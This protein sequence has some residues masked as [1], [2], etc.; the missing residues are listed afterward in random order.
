M[1]SLLS[2]SLSSS[3]SIFSS[4]LHAVKGSVTAVGTTV[5]D[6]VF[7]HPLRT[8]YFYGPRLHG[9]GFWGGLSPEDSC[10]QLT[11]VAAAMWA[12]Q[13]TACR[14]LLDRKFYSFLVAVFFAIYIWLWYILIR[15]Y[16]FRT[17]YIDPLVKEIRHI[18]SQVSLSSA[19]KSGSSIGS[20]I[21]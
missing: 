13:L 10:A 16:I 5:W 18:R 6:V 14:D 3:L 20:S 12:N 1:S 17:F 9:H 21:S 7:V 15:T 19:V 11:G 8:L 4:F 2:S